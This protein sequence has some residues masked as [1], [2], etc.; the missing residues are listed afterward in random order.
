MFTK[1]AQLMIQP[2]TELVFKR[3]HTVPFSIKDKVGKELNR[4]EEAR[5]LEKS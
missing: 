4:L 1:T 5:H 3:P 2:G